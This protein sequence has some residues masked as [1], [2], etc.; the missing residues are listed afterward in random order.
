M[1]FPRSAG[2]AALFLAA[3]VSLASAADPL[4]PAQK[5]AVREVVR[6]YL[7]ENPEVLIEALQAYEARMAEDQ[8]KQQQAVLA[9]RKEQLERDPTSPVGGAPDGDVTL[10]EFTDYRCGYCKKVFPAVHDLLKA[11]GGIRYVVK[12]LPILGPE[13]VVAAR[14]A[15]A[16][17]RSTPAKYMP[18]HAALMT[19]RG[20]LDETRILEIAAE[21]GIDSKALMTAMRDPEIAAILGKNR[22]LAQALNINGTPAFVIGGHLIPGAVEADTLRQLVA[23]ARKG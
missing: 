22:E 2:L 9:Q 12:E 1:T 7:M 19:A 15:L 6:E 16:V 5:D 14:A 13:S 4:S 23:A 10:V 3:A 21:V 20:S 18:F 11:D 8:Q 17:W